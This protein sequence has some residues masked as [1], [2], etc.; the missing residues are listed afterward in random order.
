MSPMSYD[1]ERRNEILNELAARGLRGDSTGTNDFSISNN[2][3]RKQKVIAFKTEYIF[4]DIHKLRLSRQ[5]DRLVKDLRLQV[6]QTLLED[7]KLVVGYG[8]RRCNFVI[9]HQQ[10]FLP[11]Y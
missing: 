4:P 7:T 5:I 8:V 2:A 10:N 6:G 3:K 1:K 11:K 9:T